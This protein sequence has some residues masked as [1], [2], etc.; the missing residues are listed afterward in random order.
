[1]PANKQ[2]SVQLKYFFFTHWA[3]KDVEL[4]QEQMEEMAALPAKWVDAKIIHYVKWQLERGGESNRLHLQGWCYSGI[5]T[6]CS[7]LGK[8]MHELG[9]PDF[10]EPN[11]LDI[12]RGSEEECDDYCGKEETKVCGPM[13]WGTRPPG[14]GARTDWHG[15]KHYLDNH[16]DFNGVYDVS[17]ELAVKHTTGLLYYHK[18]KLPPRNWRTMGT[19]IHG[20]TGTG[21]STWPKWMFKPECVA[22]ITQCTTDF[23]IGY[24]GEPIVHLDEFKAK[25]NISVF[26]KLIDHTAYYANVKGGDA[27]FRGVHVIITT[28]TPISQWYMDIQEKDQMT[29]DAIKGR[30]HNIWGA[31]SANR[32]GNW[33]IKD[34]LDVCDMLAFDPRVH[35]KPQGLP[36]YL[37][38]A[39]VKWIEDRKGK[40]YISSAH[41]KEWHSPFTTPLELPEVQDTDEQA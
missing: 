25:M 30:L 22:E 38:E 41:Y 40:D 32:F 8:K 23:I 26:L 34:G 24:R 13:E 14:K 6:R 16:T 27:H 10:M 4:N 11:H 19:V 29:W 33:E 20:H 17:F 39:G 18:L 21:K 28:N 15:I 9:Y 5:K 37:S 36:D 35:G 3:K 12:M 7:T 1:M 31:S 2:P